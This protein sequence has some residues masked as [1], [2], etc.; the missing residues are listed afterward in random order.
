MSDVNEN[1]GGD[2]GGG[3]G[4][5]GGGAPPAEPATE[6]TRP[7]VIPAELRD[8]DGEAGEVGAGDDTRSPDAA[9]QLRARV[10]E[11]EAEL[12][13]ARAGA[14]R[15]ERLRQ[16][17]R[18][19]FEMNAVDIETA[20][21]LVERALGDEALSG[22]ALVS[23]VRAEVGELTRSKP[24]LFKAETAGGEAMGAAHA[25]GDGGRLADSARLA[26]DHGDR[27]ELL[28]YLRLRRAAN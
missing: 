5:G 23:R 4:G 8:G 25:E 13:R 26:R 28:R 18:A 16:I 15:I 11:L 21:L 3:G 10:D 12:R 14:A 2:G 7:P 22:P 24:F 20:S 19:L 9:E 6:T 1:F 17:D 27:R